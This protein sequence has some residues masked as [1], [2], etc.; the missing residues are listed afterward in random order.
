MFKQMIQI[1]IFVAFAINLLCTQELGETYKIEEVSG[2]KY[3]HNFSAVWGKTPKVTLEFLQKLGEINANDENFQFFRPTD[4]ALDF[5]G[6]I[7]ILDSGNF[8]IQKFDSNGKFLATI[9]KKGQGPG[10]LLSSREM[11]IG[12]D[13]LLYVPDSENRRIHIFSLS[14]QAMG[15]IKMTERGFSSIRS[16]SSGELV[17]YLLKFPSSEETGMEPVLLAIMN[18]NGEI[19]NRFGKILDLGETIVNLLANKIF[20]DVDSHDNI[21]I[22]FQNENRID[23][24][25]PDGSHLLRVD[26]RLEYDV[27]NKWEMSSFE[28]EGAA[29]TFPVQDFTLVTQG[30]GIDDMDRVWVLRM[31]KQPKGSQ[32]ADQNIN[33][34]DWFVLEIFDEN[35][36]LLG[37]LSMPEIA[38]S[39]RVSGDRLFFIDSRKEMCIYEYRI[40]D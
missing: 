32:L 34:D 24:Y 6:N 18:R 3:V 16:L 9:G 23:K 12:T 15:G 35:G 33:L 38:T 31:K 40:I 7:Y 17:P 26:R 4:A 22:T 20:F 27:E 11:C 39:M 30:L 25:D 8:R 10:E 2:I 21:I 5:D 37:N 14:G 1:G 36:L 13:S 29:F 28:R 19:M